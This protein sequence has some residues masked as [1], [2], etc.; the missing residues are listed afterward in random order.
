MGDDFYLKP[1]VSELWDF[2]Q[3]ANISE[4]HSH[5]LGDGVSGGFDCEDYALSLHSQCRRKMVDII[6]PWAFGEIWF[7]TDRTKNHG[8]NICLTTKGFYLIKPQTRKMW[9]LREKHRNI[10]FV[11]F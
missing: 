2:I 8:Y 5:Y 4:I 9:K 10:F 7:E 1:T 11:Y 3:D 6:Y